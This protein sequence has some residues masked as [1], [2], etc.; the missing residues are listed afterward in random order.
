MAF[1]AALSE[2]GPRDRAPTPAR[3]KLPVSHFAKCDTNYE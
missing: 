1:M 3:M 2:Q